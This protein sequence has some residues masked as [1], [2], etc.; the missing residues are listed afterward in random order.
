[1]ACPDRKLYSFFSSVGWENVVILL[2]E[3][4]KLEN[5]EQQLREEDKVIQKY[6]NDPNCLNSMRAF[7]GLNTKEYNHYYSNLHRDE[8]RVRQATTHRELY[9]KNKAE[10]KEKRK[11]EYAEN[12]QEILKVILCSCGGKYSSSHK[13]RHEKSLIHQKWLANEN[14]IIYS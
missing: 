5:R 6:I 9:E 1:M 10:I 14:F 7:T 13:S 4:H 2:I 8:I 12:K 11:K 3:E